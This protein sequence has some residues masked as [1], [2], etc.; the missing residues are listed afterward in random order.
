MDACP[1]RF[2]LLE[3]DLEN[4]SLVTVCVELFTWIALKKLDLWIDSSSLLH[5]VFQASSGQLPAGDEFKKL[6]RGSAG[7]Y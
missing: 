6:G 1:L 4:R 5:G 7:A 2:T 3:R